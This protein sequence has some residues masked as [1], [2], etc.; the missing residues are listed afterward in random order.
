MY[1]SKVIFLG[2]T[3][4]EGRPCIEL[5]L[6]TLSLLNL[7]FRQE[8]LRSP[9]IRAS[10]IVVCSTCRLCNLISRGSRKSAHRSLIIFAASR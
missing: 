10:N 4:A 2:Y 1:Q 5:L 8:L 3:I 9:G 7:L 6:I